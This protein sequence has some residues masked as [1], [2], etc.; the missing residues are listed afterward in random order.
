MV[1]TSE[2]VYLRFHDASR[3]YRHEYSQTEV[4]A[5]ARKVRATRPKEVWAY[6]NNDFEGC[7]FRNAETFRR[8][9]G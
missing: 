8:L 6:F 7:A 3:W 4:E 1:K 5:W 9:L 2:A